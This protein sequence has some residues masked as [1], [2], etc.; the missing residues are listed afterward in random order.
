MRC[1]SI[2][3]EPATGKT[4]LMRELIKNLEQPQNFR[5]SLCQGHFSTVNN[6]AIMGI[7]DGRGTFEGT[8][9][10]SMA[11]NADFLAYVETAR[12]NIMFE[13]DRLFNAKN[14]NFINSFYEQ[15]IIVLQQSEET[16][17]QRHLE[18]N[19]TQTEKFLK[20][21]KTKIA[22]ILADDLLQIETYQLNDIGDTISLSD[23]IWSW[24][25]HDTK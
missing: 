8:D 2:G 25:T 17:H 23:N 14:L 11:V 19:D 22:N 15:R 1:V 6:I 18:R 16:L 12:R 21:R 9:R 24:I 5:F 10:L 13:G 4:T 3:G 7:Y 20:G